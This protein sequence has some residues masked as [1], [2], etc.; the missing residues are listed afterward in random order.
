VSALAAAP[1]RER[2]DAAP[3]PFVLV[4]GGKGGVGKTTLC[5]NLGVEL[6]AGGARVLLVDLDLGLSNLDVA[7]ALRAPRT[8]DDVLAGRCA[9]ADC[10]VRGPGGIDLLP[11]SSGNVAMGAPDAQRRARLCAAVRSLARGYEL[12][13]ADGA[14]GI[15][16]D[17]LGF[18]CAADRV[19]LVSTP[20]PAALT[21]A[22]GSLKALCAWSAEQ[23]TELPTPEIVVNL[24]ASLEEAEGVAARLRAVCERFLCRSP[25]LIGW[26]PRSRAIARSAREQRP[27]ALESAAQLERA[28]LRRIGARL[29]AVPR[30]GAPRALLKGSDGRAR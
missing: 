16:H 30:V 28:C 7:L 10:L 19:L 4:A 18:A 15:G 1:R 5:A 8:L 25:R 14:A 21:D 12:V 23:G 11:A 9:P 26:L 22:Y 3:A 20:E 29:L 27:F 6:A 17:L 13:L 2:T 24:A